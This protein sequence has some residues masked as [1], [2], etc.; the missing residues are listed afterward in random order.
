MSGA[1]RSAPSN[2]APDAVGRPGARLVEALARLLPLFAIAA[3]VLLL[4][5]TLAVAGDTLGFDFRAYWAAGS[6]VLA[7]QAAYDTS[8]TA[9][10]GFGLFY[11]PP[12]FIPLVLPFA[13]LPE[14]V[15]VWTWTAILVAAMVGG[16]AAMP[17]SPRLRWLVGL[18]AAASWPVLYAVKLGQVGP[19]LLL[20]FALGWRRLE[21]P[22]AAGLA[23]GLGAAVKIQPGVVLVWALLA[24]RFRDV[25]A[26]VM[27]LVV[28][29]VL[30]T[31]LAGVSA[32]TDFLTLIGRVTDPITTPHNFTVGAVA[33]QAGLSRDAA[34]VLQWASMAAA[35]VV[36]V[37][38]AVRLPAV[39]A[40]L[41]ALVA[42]QLLSPILWDHYALLLLVPTAW[43]LARGHRWA[44]L[45]P[46]STCVAFVGVIPPFVYPAAFW[47]S[48][49]AV[50]GVGYA[51]GR[52]PAA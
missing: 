34:S 36:L 28:L 37:V 43:L 10:G 18:L 38:A 13:L 5:A 15:A 23:G 1:S 11:Y 22:G 7:G 47:V 19:L 35:L 29:A 12:T 21:R 32:W 52:A 24:R 6:R 49:V 20:L 17:V 9:A 33:Y 14:T 48:L 25:V 44:V 39:P 31:L 42:S 27:V 2:T 16:I 51:E 3:G 30:A 45:I 40:Y 8:Y 50:V 46:L 26:G 41:V 4:G